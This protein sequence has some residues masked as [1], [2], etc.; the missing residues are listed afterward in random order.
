MDEFMDKRYEWFHHCKALGQGWNNKHFGLRVLTVLFKRFQ[1]KFS[2]LKQLC[3]SIDKRSRYFGG[4]SPIGISYND[5]K[6][7][8]LI[9]CV[10]SIRRS[11]KMYQ[12]SNISQILDA[13][14]KAENGKIC[15]CS[16]NIVLFIVSLIFLVFLLHHR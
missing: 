13:L 9:D 4:D 6:E 3:P 15:A 11:S 1:S 10:Y 8:K 2:N 16:T 5:R 12:P 7:G 14:H